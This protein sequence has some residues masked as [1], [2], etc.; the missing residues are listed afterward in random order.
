MLTKGTVKVVISSLNLRR[1][2]NFFVL[3]KFVDL[4]VLSLRIVM[5]V[6]LNVVSTG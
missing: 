5:Y 2:V 6:D 1:G 3:H 4:K